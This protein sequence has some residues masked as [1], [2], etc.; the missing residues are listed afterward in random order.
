V[1]YVVFNGMKNGNLKNLIMMDKVKDTSDKR[2]QHSIRKTIEQG[3]Y[4]WI[5]LRVNDNGDIKE[6]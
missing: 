6:E 5:T 2:L 1:D 3:N 4:E